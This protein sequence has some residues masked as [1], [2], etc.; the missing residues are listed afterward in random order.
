MKYDVAIIGGGL[1]GIVSALKLKEF[2]YS[3]LVIDASLPQA[4][5]SIGG[6]VKFSGAK[7]SLPPAGLGLLDVA[8]SEKELYTAISE[9]E[10]FFELDLSSSF[11]SHDVNK[12]MDSLRKYQSVVLEKE[13]INTLV[14]HLD[15]MLKSKN[16]PVVQGECVEIKNDR[17][18]FDVK[19]RSDDGDVVESAKTIFFAGGRRNNSLIKSLGVKATKGKGIDV[20]VRVEFF[21]LEDL[22]KLRSLGPDAKIIKDRCRTFCLNSPGE[23]YYYDYNGVSIPGGVVAS[24]N[25]ER[26]NFGILLRLDAK[27]EVLNRIVSYYHDIQPCL[28]E[29]GVTVESGFLGRAEPLLK[30]LYGKSSVS[31]LKDFADFLMSKGLVDWSKPHIIHMPLIDWHWDTFSV[32]GSFKT[33]ISDVYCLGDVSGHARGLLQAAVSGVLASREF[34]N[35]R[36]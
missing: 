5:G 12:E 35:G 4:E 8:G 14:N 22:K 32:K 33:S 26:A 19:I 28:I 29:N 23:V 16:I 27:A 7:F 17:E 18:L 30:E 20:G 21:S 13:E 34:K 2:G 3:P 15:G 36:S 24:C 25:V 31:K 10:T 9:V 1:A 6:F 11:E